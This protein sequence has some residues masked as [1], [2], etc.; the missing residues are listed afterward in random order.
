[1][2]YL[3]NVKFI[4]SVFNKKDI[5]QDGLPIIAMVGKSNVGK[6][7]F[8]NALANNKRIAKVGQTPGKTRCLNYF[9]VD[10]S[11]YIVD[12]PGYGYAEMSQAEKEKISLLT[13]QFLETNKNI[14]HVFALIDIRHTPTANDKGMYEW[15]LAKQ[16]PFTLI[17]NKA[18][19]L[20]KP[21]Q[22]ESIKDITKFLF[23]KEDMIPF[24]AE[25]KINLDRIIQ[26][27]KG[28]I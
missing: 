15:L 8:I 27:I 7:S 17:L 2:E 1:M 28:A 3:K 26:I 6:S 5:P 4:K 19:K 9:L 21:K 18:D 12:L 25:S 14:Q 11:F 10:D 24:S 16:I 23:A 20:S 22:E 13:N